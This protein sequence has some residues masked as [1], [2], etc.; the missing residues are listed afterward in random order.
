M[1]KFLK[2]IIPSRLKVQIL[3]SGLYQDWFRR[4][5]AKRRAAAGQRIDICASEIAIYLM[6]AGKGMNVLDGKIC[7]EVGSGWLLTHALVLYLLGAKKVYATD[8][9]P[10]LAPEIV[11]LAISNATS[12]SVVDS[13]CTFEDRDVLNARMNRLRSIRSFNRRVLSEL[14]IEYVA[15]IDICRELP[16][17]ECIDF[18]FS[19]SVLEH[20]P[21]DDVHPLLQRLARSLSADGFMVHMIHLEDHRDII[22]NPFDFLSLPGATYSRKMQTSRGNRIRKSSWDEIFTSIEELEYRPLFEWS[23]NSAKLPSVIDGSVK[24]KGEADLRVTHIGAYAQRVFAN[25]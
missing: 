21:C 1:R 2:S 23:C 25:E 22:N 14:G 13:L 4:A 17:K 8:V 16:T 9:Y 18:V 24:H 3:R 5:D 10:N 15:P 11:P 19:K 7:L 12:W 20:V 6:K